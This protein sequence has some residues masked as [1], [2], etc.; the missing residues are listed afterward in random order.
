MQ[1]PG[2]NRFPCLS[3]S[4]LRYR[5]V[6]GH[7]QTMRGEENILGYLYPVQLCFQGVLEMKSICNESSLMLNRA[8]SNSA[9]SLSRLLAQ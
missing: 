6:D 3:K 5:N 7:P 2:L 8:R 1:M 9:L 4:H